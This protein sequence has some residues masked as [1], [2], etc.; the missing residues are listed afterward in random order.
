MFDPL[1]VG[2]SS[3]AVNTFAISGVM[4]QDVL[5]EFCFPQ[6]VANENP[7]VA[8]QQRCAGRLK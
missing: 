3:F 4:Y 5:E 2:R 6:L 1:T 7:A 8:F